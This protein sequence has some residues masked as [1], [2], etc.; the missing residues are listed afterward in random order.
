M[1]GSI[2]LHPGLLI[3]DHMHF[4]YNGFLYGILVLSLVE[5]KRVNDN[6]LISVY[7]CQN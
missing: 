7:V 1:A 3:V 5:A 6:V 4:Q 2:L